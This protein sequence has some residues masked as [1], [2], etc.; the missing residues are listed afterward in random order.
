MRDYEIEKQDRSLE[1]LL[2]QPYG[3][4]EPDWEAPVGETQSNQSGQ[5]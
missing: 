4:K 2:E 5:W 1:Q 3:W